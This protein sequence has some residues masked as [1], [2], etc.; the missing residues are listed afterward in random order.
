[1]LKKRIRN[2]LLRVVATL[3]LLNLTPSAYAWGPTGHRV[4]AEIA[5]RNL[6]PAAQA[7]VSVL[8]DGRTRRCRELARR[9]AVRSAFR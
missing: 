4:V 5:Q 9:S 7:K 1:M 8:L 2:I 6:T 3:L